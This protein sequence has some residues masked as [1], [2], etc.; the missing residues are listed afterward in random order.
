MFL[1]LVDLMFSSLSI[2]NFISV[3]VYLTC[4][5]FIRSFLFFWVYFI[6]HLFTI[7]LKGMSINQTPFDNEISI[8]HKWSEVYKIPTKLILIKTVIQN[9]K[10]EKTYLNS[11]TEIKRHIDLGN[12]LR[13][14]YNNFKDDLA[15]EDIV[16][17]YTYVLL[18]SKLQILSEISS[19][20]KVLGIQEIRD[21]DELDLTL[22]DW[23]KKVNNSF[24]N[25]TNYLQ[26][27]REIQSELSKYPELDHS[28]ITVDQVTVQAFPTLK[29][30]IQASPDDGLDIFDQT[31]LSYNVPYVRYNGPT[32]NTREEL[33]KIYQGE[34]DETIPNYKFIIPSKSQTDKNDSFYFTVWSGKDLWKATKESYLNGSYDLNSNMLSIKVSSGNEQKIINRIEKSLPIVIKNITETQISGEFFVFDLDI[35]DF[36][37]VD[38]IINDDLMNAYLFIKENNTPFAEKKQIKLYFRSYTGFAEE[39]IITEG[40]IVNPSSVSV[41]LT[42]NTAQGGEIVNI[43][44][45]DGLKKKSLPYGTSFVRGKITQ[46]TSLETANQFVRIFSR[47]MSYYKYQKENIRKIFTGFIPELE[48]TPEKPEPK[49]TIVKKGFVD[50]KVERLKDIAPDIFLKGY[51]RRCQ[52]QAQPIPIPDDEIEAWKNKKFLYKDKM[53]E[54]QIMPFPPDNPKYYFVCPND[55][56][57]FPGVKINKDLPNKDIYPCLP[58]CFKDDQM[59]PK[60]NSNYNKCFSKKKIEEK[61]TKETHKVKTNKILTPERLGYLPK[62]I[63]DLLMK[64][65]SNS[66]DMS[67]MGVQKSPN[68]LLHSVSIAVQDQIY[69][70]LSTEQEKEKYVQ[71]MREIISTNVVANLMKQELY[72]FSDNDIMEKLRD[73]ENFLD[74]NLFFRAVEQTYNI[75]IYVFSLPR[76]QDSYLGSI[77]MPR[78]KLFSSRSPRPEKRT[79]L[80][81]RT[82]GSESDALDY[83]QCELIIES[84]I[85]KNKITYNFGEDMNSLLHNTFITLNQTITWQLTK[86][87][88]PDIIARDNLYSK[89]NYYTLLKKLPTKQ[90]LDGYGK[91]RAFILNVEGSNMTIVVPST[92]PENLPTGNITRTGVNI[93]INM[94]GEPNSV[95]K[96]KD[97][98]DGLW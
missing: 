48:I 82:W 81:F 2:A 39:E 25:D 34:T 43:V 69:L 36:Y 45:P 32:G 62:S 50:S 23:I 12:D 93:T 77:E 33:I 59:D 74:P 6:N 56:V 72:D 66:S 92:Q 67:R 75:N 15:A 18:Q 40:Y 65:S 30:G 89:I 51:A 9:G 1:V 42:Q 88:G 95:T 60:V 3:F 53:I 58:C 63:S 83:P 13:H 61:V 29:S 19:L 87:N 26:Y 90:I 17:I 73:K 54:R 31:I 41:S 91:T 4:L 7:I 57:P 76:K 47:L 68:S 46:A 11:F 97:M 8:L 80:I 38:M 64:Y 20:Y 37:L 85:T 86:E 84:D 10:K 35:N 27:I 70:N 94:F 71:R 21:T 16:M 79:V 49:K 44:T 14:I 5:E 24:Q 78:F 55:S 22:Q 96:S 52:C 98:V 28:E